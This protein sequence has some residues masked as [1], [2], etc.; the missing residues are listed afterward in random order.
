MDLEKPKWKTFNETDF[1]LTNKKYMVKD[2]TVL[3]NFNTGS[4]HRLVQSKLGINT[5]WER[6]K[7]TDRKITKINVQKLKQESNKYVTALEKL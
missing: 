6:K 5:K 1:I 2:V 4:D 7:L 3:N